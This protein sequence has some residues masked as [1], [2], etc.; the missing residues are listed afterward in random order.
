MIQLHYDIFTNFWYHLLAHLEVDEPSSVYNEQ[1]VNATQ[2]NFPKDVFTYLSNN[3]AVLSHFPFYGEVK[4]TFGLWES[5]LEY[6]DL[7]P[8]KELLK[9]EFQ[10]VSESFFLFLEAEYEKYKQGW[11]TE[12]VFNELNA[13]KNR[14]LEK[15]THALKFM[16]F[17]TDVEFKGD[18][19]V[20]LIN[21]LTDSRGKSVGFSNRKGFAIAVPE[22]DK[23]SEDILFVGVHELAHYFTDRLLLQNNMSLSMQKNSPEYIRRESLAD[24]VSEMYFKDIGKRITSKW[25]KQYIP[26]EIVD[27]LLN[28][29]NKLNSGIEIVRLG[30]YSEELPVEYSNETEPIKDIFFI[31]KRDNRLYFFLALIGRIVG[32]PTRYFKS[33]SPMEFD[34]VY[35]EHFIKAG[36]LVPKGK[37]FFRQSIEQIARVNGF[38][39]KVRFHMTDRCNLRC[40]YCYL[41][42]GEG[43]LLNI[44][45]ENEGLC[46]SGEINA[47][48]AINYLNKL[49]SD[50][51]YGLEVEFHGGG[52]PTLMIEEI[53]KIVAYIDEKTD[54]RIIRLQTNGVFSPNI[55]DWIVEKNIV[56]SVSLDG[57]KEIN[58]TQRTEGTDAFEKIIKNMRELVKRGVHVS[59]VSV[60]TEY[61][62]DKIDVIYEFIKSLG[63]KAMMFNPVH[64]FLG[65]SQQQDHSAKRDVDLMAFAKNYLRVK[66]KAD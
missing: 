10:I 35:R 30:K 41:S 43:D 13:F 33:L 55:I 4:S 17:V 66:Q 60:I 63:I 5:L 9:Y 1:Y 26:Q 61:S 29:Y 49:Y 31:D 27:S 42:A 38:V 6:F 51:L 50:D 39:K 14:H 24:F 34:N 7:F 47:D 3:I 40:K 46:T 36:I 28:K 12:I 32:V 64:S 58:D 20:W 21:S 2:L 25:E 22:L 18:L 48:K 16:S 44:S 37:Q 8:E 54:K 53:K 62:Q 57:N 19:H 56:V 23:M 65:R 45:C 59:T 15:F 11:Q 52:E